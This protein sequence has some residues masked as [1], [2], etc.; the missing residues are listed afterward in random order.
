MRTKKS[1]TAETEDQHRQIVVKPDDEGLFGFLLECF[2]VTPHDAPPGKVKDSVDVMPDR[3]TLRVCVLHEAGR[4]DVGPLLFGKEW[5]AT[6]APCPKA[7]ELIA[8]CNT[9]IAKA[10]HD[11]SQSGK[12]RVYTVQAFNV[13]KS[14]EA[15]ARHLITMTPRSREMTVVPDDEEL[16]GGVLS[17]KLLLGLLS[18]SERNARWMAELA[19]N[20]VSG[21]LER[22]DARLERVESRGGPHRSD[23]ERGSLRWCSALVSSDPVSSVSDSVDAVHLRR[24]NPIFRGGCGGRP[25]S[26]ESL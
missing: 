4:E 6:V 14:A 24:R 26:C 8:L 17:T 5:K 23:Q 19:M 2:H 22:S 21:A 7:E 25:A 13:G 16:G 20:T 10:Q 11:C 18:N 1:E 9:L 15:F 12:R 3:V